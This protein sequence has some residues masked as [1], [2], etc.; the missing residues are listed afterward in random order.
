MIFCFAL[1]SMLLLDSGSMTCSSL[2]SCVKYFNTLLYCKQASKSGDSVCCKKLKDLKLAKTMSEPPA[3]KQRNLA[4]MTVEN[5]MTADTREICE[6]DCSEVFFTD[7]GVI[8]T[9]YKLFEVPKTFAITP[10]DQLRLI[11]SDTNHAVLCTD[12]KT[13][14]I[15]KVE[16]SNSV[17]LVSPSEDKRFKI[18]SLHHDYYEVILLAL[19]ADTLVNIVC[20][21]V[22]MNP[23]R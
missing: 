20:V 16:T 14:A 1:L 23:I 5:C 21:F 10:N 6:E 22:T 9:S 13:Y 15:K 3:K 17:F 18:E 8:K 11:G 4:D 19:L 12:S 2:L 7:M